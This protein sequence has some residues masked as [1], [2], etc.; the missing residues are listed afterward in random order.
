MTPFLIAIGIFS[1]IFFVLTLMSVSEKG[2]RF[3][4]LGASAFVASF[5]GVIYFWCVWF[6]A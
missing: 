5:F 4:T 2:S 6:L 1:H 3:T